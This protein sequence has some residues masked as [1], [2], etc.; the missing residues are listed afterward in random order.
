[1]NALCTTVGVPFSS[2]QDTR[3]SPTPSSMIASSVLNALLG[4]NALA[5]ALT[6][7]CSAGV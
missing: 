5:A 6:A 1:M 4:L 7:F 2:R 3:A